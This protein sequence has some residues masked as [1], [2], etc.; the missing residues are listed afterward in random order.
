VKIDLVEAGRDAYQR[1]AWPDCWAALT[2]ADRTA[3]LAPADLQ[4]LAIS[5]FLTGHDES[6]YEA[7][8]RAYHAYVAADDPRSAA[9]CAFYLAFLLQD[10]G[11]RARAG[12]WVARARALVDRH[13]LG[14]AEAGLLDGLRA[15]EL[16]ESGAVA[17]ALDL[18][19]RTVTTGRAFGD[20]DVVMLALLSVGHA[21]V[22]RGEVGSAVACLDEVMLAV[23]G[24]ELI[25][26]VAGLAYCSVIAACMRLHDLRR[27]R[28][29]TAALSGWCDAQPG[30]VP[31]RGI[32]LV[33]R[34]ELMTLSG[35][36][37]DA[38]VEAT[39]ASEF[40]RAS[41]A[42]E[43]FYRLGELHRLRGDFVA[44]ET[45]Y[46]RANTGG[47]LPEPGLLRL[48][49]AQGRTDVAA[50][51]A[52]HLLSQ[53]GEGMV[54]IEVL[55]ACIE[56]AMHGHDLDL[57][58]AATNELE[59]LAGESDEPLLAAFDDR[60][61]GQLLLAEQRPADALPVLRRGWRAFQELDLP[62]EA[63][64]VRTLIGE[65]CRAL[66]DEDAAQM[67]LD[68]AR[69]WFDQLGAVPDRDRVAAV[70]VATGRPADGGLTARELQVLRLVAAG[71]TNRAVADE[72]FL[73][74][75]TVARHVSNIFTK[76]DVPS[77]SAAT[78]YAY[79]H[80]L[81]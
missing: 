67:E 53:V 28:E 14:G 57:A 29:W 34:A 79:E 62:Y 23:S 37:A 36:W 7:L 43:A 47:R 12:G 77:R 13:D 46:R 48:R 63:A 8:A 42:A 71:R 76:L 39:R 1:Q 58:R 73:S 69:W 54:R 80:G 59:R 6:S 40:L 68:A 11:E 17:E 22:S 75:K 10:T 21:H 49:L 30:L 72:L 4:L 50:A 65:C 81:L 38:L 74:E 9:R 51:T 32:C 60:A 64:Q 3:P 24:D 56:A 33:H 66:G 78:A 45:A 70:A 31:Y 52:R 19:E 26:P 27:A 35:N 55:A 41:A 16:L 61:A 15:H 25:P 20:P 18:A 44:A 5:G 2:D